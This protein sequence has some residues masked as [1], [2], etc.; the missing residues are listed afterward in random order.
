MR[1]LQPDMVAAHAAG[2]A[3]R[4][5]VPWSAASCVKLNAYRKAHT[6]EMPDD[7]FSYACSWQA[8]L[9]PVKQSD[10]VTCNRNQARA[11]VGRMPLEGLLVVFNPYHHH[12]RAYSC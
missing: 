11:Q 6:A 10:F 3:A 1:N 12:E 7:G 8:R 2:V 9:S 4:A 5:A